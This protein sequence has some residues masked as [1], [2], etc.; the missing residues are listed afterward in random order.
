MRTLSSPF[1]FDPFEDFADEK[2]PVRMLMRPD[3]DLRRAS[4]LI[5][6]AYE[7]FIP[8]SMIDIQGQRTPSSGV[9]FAL[10]R[11][12]LA[13]LEVRYAE[14]S[15]RYQLLDGVQRLRQ[16]MLN[17]QTHVIAFVEPDRDA[18]RAGRRAIGLEATRIRPDGA[19][20]FCYM[21]GAG[22]TNDYPAYDVFFHCNGD[23]RLLSRYGNAFM[24]WQAMTRKIDHDY[25]K[26]TVEEADTHVVIGLREGPSQLS[27]FEYS[28][29]QCKSQP[30]AYP[31]L[32]HAA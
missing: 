9:A 15:N 10:G 12:I 30:T 23:K 32:K 27:A 1:S 31:S 18:L 8:L 16:A 7:R 19:S 28:L 6:C 5:S 29:L 13:P 26:I 4:S 21:N 20:H 17:R 2:L 14:R 3:L 25:L 24:A 22:V 11:E